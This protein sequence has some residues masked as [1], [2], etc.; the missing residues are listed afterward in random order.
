MVKELLFGGRGAATR[1]GDL[2]LLVLRGYAGI[3]LAAAHGLGKLPPPDRFITGVGELGFPVPVLFAW[4]AALSSRP[5]TALG[6]ALVAAGAGWVLDAPWSWWIGATGAAG[7]RPPSWK[8]GC[9]ECW[10]GST[11]SSTRR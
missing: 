11:R 3:S 9:G 6:A 7:T 8:R 5:L 4:A 1:L 10:N 2:G